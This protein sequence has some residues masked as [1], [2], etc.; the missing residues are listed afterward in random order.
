MGIRVRKVDNNFGI[1]DSYNC[2]FI[3]P[4]YLG[5][6]EQEILEYIKQHPY[7]EEPNPDGFIYSAED[8]IKD[9]TNSEGSLIIPGT[10]AQAEWVSEMIYNFLN[11]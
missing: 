3:N 10:E 11:K 7:P 5:I 1:W 6:T 2:E 9:L 4:K 8:M